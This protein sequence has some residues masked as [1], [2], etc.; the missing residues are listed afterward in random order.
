MEAAAYQALRDLQDK[1]WWFVGRR[2]F[3]ASLIDRFIAL[4]QRPRI[5]EAGCGYGGNLPMLNRLGELSAFEFDEDARSHASTMI[6]RPV[7]AGY[8]PGG[9]GFGN[10]GF[11]MIAMLD[12]L[13]HIDDDV[14]S[15]KVLRERLNGE[16]TIL[17]TVPAHPWLWSDHDEVH[18]HK[19][20]YTPKGLREVL[21][22][23]GF[24]KVNIGYFNS[25]LFPL[26][27]LQRLLSRLSGQRLAAD[28]M[29]HPYVNRLLR[30]VFEFES[31]ML[32]RIRLPIGL[33]LY[34]IA[35]RTD[36]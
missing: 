25:L 17:I 6:E 33:S 11:D 9:V 13:E 29:P 10:E 5:L 36:P 23:A 16:G 21:L 28:N 18:H 35:Q 14:G 30:T 19:R 32:G 4:P 2:K 7:E 22:E 20:R 8:L 12:V 1:H 24:S 34:A 27:L 15:L 26:A 31:R 3:I